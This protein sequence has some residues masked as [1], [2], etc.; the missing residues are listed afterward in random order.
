MKKNFSKNIK[1]VEKMLKEILKEDLK[2][3]MKEKNKVAL[4]TVKSVNAEVRNTEIDLKKELEDADILS[5]IKKQIKMRK[6]SLEQ[7][8]SA[9]RQDLADR[10][11]EELNYLE[12]YLPEQ[13]DDEELEKIIKHTIEELNIQSPKEFGKLMKTVMEKIEGKAEGSKISALAKK[14]MS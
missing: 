6:D 9:G 8:V 2:K 7:Y 14:L 1:G 10:E 4:D 12:G 5:I 3:Y 13:I 11:Q